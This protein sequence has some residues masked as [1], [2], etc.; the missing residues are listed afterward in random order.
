MIDGVKY[1]QRS[2]KILYSKN[3]SKETVTRGTVDST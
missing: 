1:E 3:G 2:R